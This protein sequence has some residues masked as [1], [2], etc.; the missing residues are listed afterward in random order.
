MPDMLWKRFGSYLQGYIGTTQL[1]LG[2]AQRECARGIGAGAPTAQ[3]FRD[4]LHACTHASAHVCQAGD[5]G[6]LSQLCRSWG[7]LHAILLA[8]CLGKR[9]LCPPGKVPGLHTDPVT[10]PLFG[11]TLQNQ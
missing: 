9:C 11:C 1:A 10:L 8:G 2:H 3:P 7:L 6:E 4:S 5:G